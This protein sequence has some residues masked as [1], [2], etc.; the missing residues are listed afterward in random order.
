MKSLRITIERLTK[1]FHLKE[2]TN[3]NYHLQITYTIKIFISLKSLS[4]IEYHNLNNYQKIVR[5]WSK[6]SHQ[7]LGTYNLNWVTKKMRIISKR[8]II[9]R[10]DSQI[11]TVARMLANLWRLS[12]RWHWRINQIAIQGMEWVTMTIKEEQKL[13]K[14]LS[15]N[16]KWRR[17][18]FSLKTTMKVK[19]TSIKLLRLQK[20]QLLRKS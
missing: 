7:Q 16:H 10:Q 20:I 13:L 4:S 8:E 3:L 1:I 12:Q 18:K 14:N 17:R 5:I 11:K 19:S 6:N 2:H 15:K 9:Q